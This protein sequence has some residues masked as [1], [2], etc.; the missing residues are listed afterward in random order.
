MLVTD[1]IKRLMASGIP[2]HV[3]SSQDI[4]FEIMHIERLHVTTR[5]CATYKN[6]YIHKH[7][8]AYN[9]DHINKHGQTLH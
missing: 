9:N 1:A 7:P 4:Q 5:L 2:L 6:D 3:M 8:E